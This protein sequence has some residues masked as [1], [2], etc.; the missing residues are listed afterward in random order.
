M[1]SLDANKGS[2]VNASGTKI[3]AAVALGSGKLDTTKAVNDAHTLVKVG[4]LQINVKTAIAM[5]LLARNASDA[6]VELNGATAPT[7]T[8]K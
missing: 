6:L 4:N 8:T 2:S 5:G 3:A 7:V 1:P